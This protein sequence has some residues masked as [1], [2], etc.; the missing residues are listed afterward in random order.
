MK[1][2]F[3]KILVI[4]TTLYGTF[5]MASITE[6]SNAFNAP[7]GIAFDSQGSMY[8]TNWSNNSITKVTNNNHIT[9]FYTGIASPAGIV[10]DAQDNIYVASYSDDYIL[11]ITPKGISEKISDGYQTPTGI[12]WSHTGELLI[13]N[14]ANGEIIALNVDSG[15]KHVVAKGFN[16]PVGVTE[17]AD[18]SLVIS[19]YSGRL[20]HIT[21]DG[22]KTELGTLFD[23]PGVGITTIEEHQ[24]AVIDNGAGA[25]REVNVKTGESKVLAENLPGAVALTLYKAAYY[26]GTWN[27]GSV[28][29]LNK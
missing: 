18:H 17:L 24:I 23:R 14:R 11:R 20:T 10:V 15:K 7:T 16:L 6:I 22:H 2:F 13:T 8:V 21:A 1:L 5:C 25:V 27:N 4:L 19:Q 29:K 28:Y 12:A 9:L 3:I 26:I